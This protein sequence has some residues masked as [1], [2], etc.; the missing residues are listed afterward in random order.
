M[1]V[2]YLDG[3]GQPLSG[4]VNAG[5]L[6]VTFNGV[7]HFSTIVG[8]LPDAIQV[9][10]DIKPGETPNVVNPGSKGTIPVAVM[11]TPTFDVTKIDWRLV[12]FSGAHV[13][14]NKK[15]KLQ[16]AIVDVNGDGIDDVVAQF[17]T[18]ELLLTRTDTQAVVEGL[19][20]DGRRF[21]G[22]DSVKILK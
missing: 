1:L 4:I 16:I 5:G 8:L 2:P 10:V 14:Q 13:A 15:G 18:A 20:L 22:S 7:N 11:S 3:S 9:D 21:R 19:T 12:T 17:Q 6:S